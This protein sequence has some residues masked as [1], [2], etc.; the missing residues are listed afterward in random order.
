MHRSIFS[1][2]IQRRRVLASC[3]VIITSLGLNACSGKDDKP[4]G[5]VTGLPWQIE[6]FEDGSSE[7]FGV[8]LNQTTLAEVNELL[9]EDVEKAIIVDQSNQTGLEMY[10]KRFKAGVL[11]GKLILTGDFSPSELEA[12]INNLDQGKYMA[13]GARILTPTP[14]DWET[15]QHHKVSAIAFVPAINLDR[16]LIEQRFGIAKEVLKVD[17]QLHFL[18]PSLGLSIA[19][20]ENGKEVLQY[21]APKHFHKLRQPL[22][23]NSQSTLEKGND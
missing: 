1:F 20:N 13:S 22:L 18:Y 21:V 7:V 9:G 19:L 14:A 5:N 16:D 2:F 3:I 12:M 17:D 4:V 15:A 6:T 8:H 23:N 10:L 11:E